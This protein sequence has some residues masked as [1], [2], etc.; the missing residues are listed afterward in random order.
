MQISQQ[1]GK[2]KKTCEIFQIEDIYYR[3]F[4][5]RHWEAGRAKQE[6]EGN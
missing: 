1:S 6:V 4:F 5:S 3:E 2:F